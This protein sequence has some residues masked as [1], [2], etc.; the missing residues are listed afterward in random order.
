MWLLPA[1]GGIGMGGRGRI[2]SVNAV[3]DKD[4]VSALLAE[5]AQCKRLII[6]TGVDYV[7]GILREPEK[8]RI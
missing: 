8:I 5:S 1:A 3:I 4:F 2:V 7:S 6:L